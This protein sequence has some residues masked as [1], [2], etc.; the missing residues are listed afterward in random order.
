MTASS[1]KHHLGLF[2]V[3]IAINNFLRLQFTLLNL[4]KNAFLTGKPTKFTKNA[5]KTKESGV[6]YYFSAHARSFSLISALLV[7][8]LISKSLAL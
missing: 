3:V 4:N 1:K 5:F 8:M 2:L 7:L 6:G